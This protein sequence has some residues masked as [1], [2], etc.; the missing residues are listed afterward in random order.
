MYERPEDAAAHEAWV[1]TVAAALSQGKASACVT[2]LGDEG[3]ARVRR[4]RASPSSPRK[5]TQALALPWLRAA[6]TVPTQASCAAASSGRSYIAA[7]HQAPVAVGKRGCVRRH[8]GH[9]PAKH[10]QL[11]NRHLCGRGVQVLDDRLGDALVDLVE[12]HLRRASSTG[13]PSPRPQG[14]TVASW[15]C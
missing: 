8:S 2:F 3:D 1:G 10:T 6:A 14:I 12:E 7:T 9:R 4:T 13:W 5:V 15:R 11:R